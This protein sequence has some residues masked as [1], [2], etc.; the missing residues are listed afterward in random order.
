MADIHAAFVFFCG[1]ISSMNQ[2]RFTSFCTDCDLVG[3]QLTVTDI[4]HIFAKAVPSQSISRKI[5]FNQFV[6]ALQQLAA[7]RECT[8]SVLA[9][10]IDEGRKRA[11]AKGKLCPMPPLEPRSST[12]SPA[13][14][15]YCSAKNT[16]RSSAS[17]A[18]ELVTISRADFECICEQLRTNQLLG[19]PA[20]N[21]LEE[22]AGISQKK[23]PSSVGNIAKGFRGKMADARELDEQSLQHKLEELHKTMKQKDKTIDPLRKGVCSLPSECRS[24]SSSASSRRQ[25]FTSHHMDKSRGEHTDHT[26]SNISLKLSQRRISCASRSR[27]LSTQL[28]RNPVGLLHETYISLSSGPDGV[29]MNTFV[30]HCRDAHLVDKAFTSKDAQRVFGD[31]ANKDDY[32]YFGITFAQFKSVLELIAEHKCIDV[33][34]VSDAV[35]LVGE[36]QQQMEHWLN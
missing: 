31:V 20:A 22:A 28:E 25:S 10:L 30:Q 6:I 15:K 34:N 2:Q 33:T 32:G 9:S 18:P 13:S 12:S 17:S 23:S 35:C 19:P 14:T 8:F 26:I 21:A 36:E 27:R 1:D 4:E 3:E 24:S 29:Q 5:N 11:Q 7:K 16:P